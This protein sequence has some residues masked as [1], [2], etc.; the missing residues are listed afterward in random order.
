MV[1]L[2]PESVEEVTTGATA[3]VT[4]G[5]NYDAIALLPGVAVDGHGIESGCD[6]PDVAK[7]DAGEVAAPAHGYRDAT[8]GRQDDV[9]ERF[10]Q[11]EAFVGVLP[12]TVDTVRVVGFTKCFLK[13]NLHATGEKM[14][15]LLLY[16]LL[17]RLHVPG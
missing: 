9:T 10:P 17:N 13:R 1:L 7:G 12:D 16:L 14:Q 11:V 15:T 8:K 2:L 4:D 3:R 6:V 5:V